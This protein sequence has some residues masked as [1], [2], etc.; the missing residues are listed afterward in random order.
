M[1][2]RRCLHYNSVPKLQNISFAGA[3][4]LG[5]DD[6]QC[7]MAVAPSL[8]ELHIGRACS[9]SNLTDV[10]N[11]RTNLQLLTLADYNDNLLSALRKMH[12]TLQTLRLG[13]SCARLGA[14]AYHVLLTRVQCLHLD[15]TTC[16][17][18]WRLLSRMGQKLHYLI[19]GPNNKIGR[20]HGCLA[21]I[22][23]RCTCLQR[24]VIGSDNALTNSDW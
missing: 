24:L 3:N 13:V 16:N 17:L 14:V 12:Q 6:W 2:L 22:C 11:A 10:L 5:S 1:N 8:M 7:V 19:I 20:R 9:S 4:G 18:L 23:K 15:H 21:A